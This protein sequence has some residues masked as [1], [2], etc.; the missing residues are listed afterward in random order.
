M[1]QLTQQARRQFLSAGTTL[2]ASALLPATQAR[3]SAAPMFQGFPQGFL[4]GAATA[5]HQVEGNNVSSDSWLLENMQPTLFEEPSGDACDHYRLFSQDIG[6][7]AD[8]GLNT[9]RFSLEWARIE[10]EY[11]LFSNAQLDHYRQVLDAC[12]A[13][14]IIPMVTFSHFTVP[15]WFA[16][17]G[18][19][20]HADG[21]QLFARFCT[22][23]A[24]A[25][26][27]GM[28]YAT[29]LNEPN[30][31]RLLFGIPGLESSRLGTATDLKILRLAG[32]RCGTG[33][34]SS[35]IF[36]SLEQIHQGLLNAHRLGYQA[37]KAE[38]PGLPVGVSLAMTDDQAVTPEAIPMR[39]RK[40]ALAYQ[41]WF[42]SINAGHADFIGVQSYSRSRI[43]PEG[44]LPPE[45][46]MPLTDM[47]YEFYPEALEAVIRY[48]RSQVP[49]PIYV[50]ENG[51]ATT[52]D[53]RRVE[54][55]RRAVQGVA[56]CLQDTLDVRGYIHWSL[57]DN[58]EWLEGYKP[59]FGLVA[60]DRTTFARTIKPSAHY[61]GQIARTGQV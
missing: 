18:G 17:R 6:L 41:P 2:L 43:G 49:V 26:G 22:T 14:G 21:P 20:E 24:R 50:T 37:I 19:W 10:P 36:G 39:E 11:G 59:R 47:G 32:E 57:L 61:L 7:L 38:R 8:L 53:T 46:G 60:V 12:R 45:P 15:R 54:Y 28:G 58:F 1:S 55:I 25:L 34:F 3:A 29:T 56:R 35:W 30:L 44:M 16:G 33:R 42:E 13:R 5:G 9:F 27:A 51:V 23:A 4:W 40:R 48:T 52:D 31:T